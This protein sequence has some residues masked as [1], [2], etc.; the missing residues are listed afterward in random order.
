MKRALVLPLVVAALAAC[1][2]ASEEL[3]ATG[4]AGFDLTPSPETASGTYVTADGWTVHVERF[5]VQVSVSATPLN[6]GYGNSEPYVFDATKP[7]QVFAPALP[8]GPARVNISLYGRYPSYSD[9]D[10]V[11]RVERINVDEETNDRFK[12][13]RGA[14]ANVVYLGPSV[15][16]VLRAENASRTVTL[17]AALRIT[18]A[19]SFDD[20]RGFRVEIPEDGIGAVPLFVHVEGLFG[21]FDDVAAADANGDGRV[22]GEELEASQ[23]FDRI[24]R[25][26]S[27]LF[28]QR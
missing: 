24:E 6:L 28:L 8:V 12:G 18:T 7:A 11:D 20:E 27:S 3:P 5:F 23:S 4:A 17:D 19:P 25:R 16:A 21:S 26:A 2:P 13:V 22:T 1:V 14:D 9:N 15:I 10:Y